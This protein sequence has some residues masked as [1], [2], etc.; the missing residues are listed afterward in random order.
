MRTTLT[1]DDDVAAKLRAEA[2]RCGE[3]FKQTVNR[4]LRN[5]LN[6]QAQAA[7]VPPYKIKARS[8]GSKGF[9]YDKVWELLEEAE[10]SYHR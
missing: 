7:S 10:G 6:V 2:R 9:N 4:L 5:G 1:L 8:W 3:P